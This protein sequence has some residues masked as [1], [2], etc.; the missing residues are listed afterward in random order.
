MTTSPQ[1]CILSVVRSGVVSRLRHI[2]LLNCVDGS[3]LILCSR[4]RATDRQPYPGLLSTLEQ[5]AEQ[6]TH[7][8][9]HED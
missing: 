9:E 5:W 2:T 7:E 8:N 1:T 6:H 4:C 3:T